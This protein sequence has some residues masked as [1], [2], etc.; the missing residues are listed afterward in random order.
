MVNDKKRSTPLLFYAISPCIHAPTAHVTDQKPTLYETVISYVKIPRVERFR[1]SHTPRSPSRAFSLKSSLWNWL[2]LSF[3]L[4]FPDFSR[5]PNSPKQMSNKKDNLDMSDLGS[6]LPA[7]AAG[8]TH[9]LPFSNL[10]LSLSYICIQSF[11]H[12]C[13]TR[14][15]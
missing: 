12:P 11:I 13:I 6:S 8:I 3:F 2:Y 1:R 15:Y 7:A 14:H 10:H 4:Q 5:R 9:F